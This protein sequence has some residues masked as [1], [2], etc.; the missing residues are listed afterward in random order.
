MGAQRADKRK[1]AYMDVTTRGQERLSSSRK[2]VA[3]Q[4]V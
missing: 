1:R 2:S 3:F 4:R